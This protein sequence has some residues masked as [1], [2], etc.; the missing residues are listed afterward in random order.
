VQVYDA[1]AEAALVQQLGLGMDADGQCALATAHEDR[2]K[3]EMALVN[4]PLGDRL[5]GELG[6]ADRDVG[7]RP[8]FSRRTAAT[9]NSRSILVLSLEIV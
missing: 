1:A 6:P 7:S 2:P 4:Q 5:T 8:P 3:K 9:S